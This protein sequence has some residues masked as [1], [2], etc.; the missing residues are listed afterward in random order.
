MAYLLNDTKKLDNLLDLVD[1]AVLR[2]GKT[3]VKLWADLSSLALQVRLQT[4]PK[5]IPDPTAYR[6][7]IESY[8]D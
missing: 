5:T 3:D 7:G 4:H 6:R 2:Y 8:I 1:R